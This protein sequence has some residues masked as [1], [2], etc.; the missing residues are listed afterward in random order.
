M[1]GTHVAG[2][3]AAATGN[4]VGIAGV[5]P[6]AKIM[7]IKVLEKGSGSFADI[8]SG[9]RY[10]ADQGAKVVNLS[11]GAL[12]GAQALTLTGLV[13]DVTQAIAHASSKGVAVIA[14]AGN[15]AAPLCATPAWEP[16]AMFRADVHGPDAARP[17]ARV[18]TP[19]YGWGLV[20]AQAAVA[21]P[22]GQT[23]PGELA[24]RARHA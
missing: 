21:A 1:H 19:V 7:P 24:R 17:R 20:D 14:A 9:I 8:A 13:A 2:I 12:P 3:A 4:G 15:E 18:Y 22:R 6:D 10:F 23:R 5:A 16:G 11:L